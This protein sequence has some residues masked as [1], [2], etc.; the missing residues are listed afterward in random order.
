MMIEIV[1]WNSR[2]MMHFRKSMI[3]KTTVF[4]K[5][6]KDEKHISEIWS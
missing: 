1:M 5:S 6:V 2:D 4:K 3:A